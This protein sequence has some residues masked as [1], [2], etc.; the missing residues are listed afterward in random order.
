MLNVPRVLSVHSEWFRLGTKIYKKIK[1]TGKP[2]RKIGIFIT[3]INV[4]L[5]RPELCPVGVNM[6]SLVCGS[7][8]TTHGRWFSPPK[9]SWDSEFSCHLVAGALIA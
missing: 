5:W 9:V 3:V 2:T 4:H 6:L 1:I 8:R 7:Q